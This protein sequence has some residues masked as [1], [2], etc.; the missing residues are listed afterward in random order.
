MKY[1]ILIFF[2][3]SLSFYGCKQGNS[4]EKTSVAITKS[5]IKTFVLPEIPI[6]L[7]MPEQRADY[8]ASH[9]WDNMVVS[10]QDTIFSYDST[11]IEQAWVNYCSLLNGMSYSDARAKV[12]EAFDKFGQNK[13]AFIHFIGLAEKYWYDPN[14]PMRCE[15]L[16]IPVLEVIMNSSVLIDAEKIRPQ[17]HLTMAKKNRVGEQAINFNY[18]L[19]S[20]KQSTLYG[21]STEYILL[22]I[23]NPGCH[24]CEIVIGQLKDSEVVNKL[25]SEK[26]LT[27]LALYTDE[28][29]AEWNKHL[30]D[31][32]K[33]WINAYDR[34]QIISNKQLYDLKAIP[35]LYLLDKNKQVL[36]K[37][38]DFGTLYDYLISR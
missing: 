18:T 10:P 22:F 16:Y 3:L 5:D 21:I 34:N 9:Y 17:M 14:S 4:S 24:A 6:M 33:E 35:T 37:D 12:K 19:Q 15:E 13:N 20:G 36:L 2:L 26:R 28:D 7:E 31:F 27:I 8:L 11:E 38:V 29:L 23:N 25:I 32:P 1:N 30:P